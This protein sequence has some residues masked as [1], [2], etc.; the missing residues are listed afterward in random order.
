VRSA[1]DGYTLLSGGDSVELNR[2]LMPSLPY[3]PERDLAPV[4]RLA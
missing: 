3:D 2:Y 1:P 4:L